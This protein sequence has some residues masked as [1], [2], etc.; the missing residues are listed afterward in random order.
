MPSTS[1]TSISSAAFRM[2]KFVSSNQSISLL[3]D[4]GAPYSGI[5][6]Q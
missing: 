5:G 4:D 6:I 2:A 1:T 3:L